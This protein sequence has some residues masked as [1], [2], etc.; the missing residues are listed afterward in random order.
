MFPKSVYGYTMAGRCYIALGMKENAI[1]MYSG[2]LNLVP[3]DD[4]V[5]HADKIQL[6]ERIEQRLLQLGQ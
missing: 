3:T 6:K 2:A 4:S 5:N 1:A